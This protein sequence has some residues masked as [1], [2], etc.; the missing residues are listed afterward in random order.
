VTLGAHGE[1]RA[2]L[3]KAAWAE[4]YARYQRDCGGWGLPAQP[5]DDFKA[6]WDVF[7]KHGELPP[8]T[9]PILVQ[10]L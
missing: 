6:Y 7:A 10:R 9:A 1:Y 5:F 3:A 4:R 2:M 8:A